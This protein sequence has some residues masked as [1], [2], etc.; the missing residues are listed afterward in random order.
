[1]DRS[2]AI[3]PPAGGSEPA[4][5]WADNVLRRAGDLRLAAALLVLAAVWN[6]IA[7]VW[8]TGPASLDG[9]LYAVLL[10]AI[11]LTGLAGVAVRIPVAWREWRRPGPVPEGRAAL[12][13]T[14]ETGLAPDA[15]AARVAALGYRTRA[16]EGRAGWAV[17]GTRR[18]WARFAGLG[19]HVALMLLLVGAAVSGA[20]ASEVSFSLLP[21]EQALLGAP[22][23]GF[24]DA[25]RLDDLDAEFG[26]DGRP[27]RLDTTVTF[28]RDGSP[29]SQ[30]VLQ[31]NA[32]GSFGGALVHAWTYGP[33]V[34]LRVTTLG[35]R[36]LHDAPV[37]LSALRD[38]RP[39]GTLELP[40]V[41]AGVAIVLAD[42]AS[43]TVAVSAGP[44]GRA[45]DA[46]LLRP[47]ETRRV[48]EVEVR[49]GT[50]SS[51]V[52]F[53]ARRDPGLPIL[54][55]GGA[56]LCLCLA[57][58]FWLPRRRLT[59]RPAAGVLRLVLRGGRF[60]QPAAELERLRAA[61]EAS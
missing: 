60:D 15:V 56:A 44:A 20:N 38:G 31:V 30:E 39:A 26:T 54:V 36:V 27:R 10:G 49:L 52:T 18:G 1:M 24:T 33:A 7:A 13:T 19:S 11:V 58:V 29:V 17:H 53:L 55:A 61:L 43:N 6:V 12:E 45:A 48:G 9:P 8:P 5:R 21:G 22:R 28:L 57:A 51:W 16:T 35:G 47:G 3:A 23:P 25:V 59:V 46:V 4:V 34:G 50:F 40:S 14:V 32:P 41:G 37:P 2:P 42:A